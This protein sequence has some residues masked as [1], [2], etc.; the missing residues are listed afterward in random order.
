MEVELNKCLDWGEAP[1]DMHQGMPNIVETNPSRFC[2]N[3][4]AFETGKI[5]PLHTIARTSSGPAFIQNWNEDVIS[6]IQN[7]LSILQGA[8]GACECNLVE[9]T[10]GND[11][12]DRPA[13]DHPI[14]FRMNDLHILESADMGVR[15]DMTPH[16]NIHSPGG[17]GNVPR[18]VWILAMPVGSPCF[19]HGNVGLRNCHWGVLVTHRTI[20]EI[21]AV[22]QNPGQVSEVL[23]GPVLGVMYEC[24]KTPENGYKEKV[25]QPFEISNL[26]T[27]WPKFSAQFVG[28]TTMTEV[29]IFQQ[30]IFPIC[31][32]AEPRASNLCSNYSP[33]QRSCQGYA[34]SLV[35]AISPGCVTPSHIQRSLSI[36]LQSLRG[37][38][39]A[40]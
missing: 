38:W 24:A 29:E 10:V 17:A 36:T 3:E 8:F 6:R 19:Q 23:G 34:Y 40:R 31:N 21:K 22:L 35:R 20:D 27:D 26:S 37:A 39:I 5:S 32:I 9:S 25:V 30:G 1:R 33:C 16:N 14:S 18:S 4:T 11:R 12:N 13:I 2:I 15:R 7:A 28:L